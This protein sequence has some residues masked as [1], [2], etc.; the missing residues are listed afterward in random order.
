MLK[1][2]DYINTA[3]GISVPLEAVSIIID[4]YSLANLNLG[5]EVL[6]M[7]ELFF[8]TTRNIVKLLTL[9]SNANADYNTGTWATIHS[10]TG[11]PLSYVFN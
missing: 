3:A 4:G 9:V 7:N 6:P 8:V 1:Y 11:I 5:L 10:S 2:S